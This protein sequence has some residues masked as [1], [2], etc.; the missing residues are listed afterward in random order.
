MSGLTLS[1]AAGSG[2]PYPIESVDRRI[3]GRT[4]V[5]DVIGRTSTTSPVAVVPAAPPG[6]TIALLVS[7]TDA[8]AVAG[9]LLPGDP[10]T[11]TTT[12]P[13]IT[14]GARVVVTGL[15]DAAAFTD[16]GGLRRVTLECVRVTAS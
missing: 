13:L 8:A 10:V 7:Q 4:I 5:Y 15:D 2:G 9:L 12:C 11:L 1:T 6:Y 3:E 14:S 16:P